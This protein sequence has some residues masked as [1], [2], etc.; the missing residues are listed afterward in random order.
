MDSVYQKYKFA[1]ERITHYKEKMEKLKKY[2][3]TQMINN[4]KVKKKEFK[5]IFR[6]A[7][8]FKKMY[9]LFNYCQDQLMETTNKMNLMKVDH[10]VHVLS[11]VVLTD[12]TPSLIMY[13]PYAYLRSLSR[14]LLQK[15]DEEFNKE[16]FNDVLVKENFTA[17]KTEKDEPIFKWVEQ[18]VPLKE[19]DKKDISKKVNKGLDKDMAK[20][21]DFLKKNL[22][23]LEMNR[24][25]LNT[26]FDRFGD[27]FRQKLGEPG[28]IILN[29]DQQQNPAIQDAGNGPLPIQL[30][31]MRVGRGGNDLVEPHSG[32]SQFN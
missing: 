8:K 18:H 14:E 6:N 24:N 13:Q 31:P 1:K 7:E 30:E 12:I 16:F 28:N 5:H 32:K 4:K 19:Q 20:I 3:Q 29:W 27:D 22:A 17:M 15:E 25:T 21:E 23:E 2:T 9:K 26:H 11:M 10:A